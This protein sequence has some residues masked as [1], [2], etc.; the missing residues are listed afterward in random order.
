MKSP[1][2]QKFLVKCTV[3][4]S[5]VFCPSPV[6]KLGNSRRKS[7]IKHCGSS[8][9]KDKGSVPCT[10]ISPRRRLH[11]AVL[12]KST[13][14][15]FHPWPVSSSGD[16]SSTTT[17]VTKSDAL[18]EEE[19]SPPNTSVHVSSCRSGSATSIGIGSL[20]EVNCTFKH[21]QFLPS[22]VSSGQTTMKCKASIQTQE[23][24][25]RPSIKESMQSYKIYSSDTN[26]FKCDNEISGTKNF[27]ERAAALESL[28][29]LCAEL[30][31][32]NRLEELGGIL[33]PFGKHGASPRETAIWLSKSLK[34]INQVHYNRD[35]FL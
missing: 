13:N 11:S 24:C 1:H 32:Q 22:D 23:N 7:G 2:L 16:D 33:K 25:E 9:I 3:P 31:E 30:L 12:I 8:L 10:V 6:R 29:E 18:K 5:P 17:N 28:L 21:S 20:H 26:T 4:P 35:K 34:T 19:W 27:Q 14:D 15:A